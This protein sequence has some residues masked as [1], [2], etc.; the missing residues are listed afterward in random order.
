MTYTIIFFREQ[1]VSSGLEFPGPFIL[2][3]FGFFSFTEGETNFPVNILLQF[4]LLILIYSFKLIYFDIL[5]D[6]CI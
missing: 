5:T 2:N 4:L 3:Q 1:P 6:D